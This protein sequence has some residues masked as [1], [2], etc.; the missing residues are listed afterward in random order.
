[1]IDPI[2]V[3][4]LAVE[5]ELLTMEIQPCGPSTAVGQLGEG[6]ERVY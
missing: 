5:E 6:T 3:V 1:M 4:V 2:M